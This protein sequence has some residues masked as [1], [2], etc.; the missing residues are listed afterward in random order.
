MI[1]MLTVWDWLNESWHSHK[2]GYSSAVIA[3][4]EKIC[5]T[6]ILIILSYFKPNN[7]PRWLVSLFPLIDEKTQKLSKIQTASKVVLLKFSPCQLLILVLNHGPNHMGKYSA[8]TD[9]LLF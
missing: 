2:T 5:H 1:Q 7:I 3:M 8:F 4:L 9:K 6:R